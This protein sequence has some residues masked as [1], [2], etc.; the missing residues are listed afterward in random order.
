[1]PR[2]EWRRELTNDALEDTVAFIMIV[3]IRLAMVK[4]ANLNI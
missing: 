3:L 4:T 1:M 2:G